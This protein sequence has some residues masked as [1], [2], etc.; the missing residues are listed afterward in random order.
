MLH[1]LEVKG[2]TSI[3][4]DASLRGILGYLPELW[5]NAYL[6]KNQRRKIS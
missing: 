6:I 1:Q 4:Q 5:K 2:H 3:K